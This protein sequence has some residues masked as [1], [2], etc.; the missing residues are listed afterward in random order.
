MRTRCPGHKFT[1]SLTY[2]HPR[3]PQVHCGAIR[4][5]LGFDRV[6]RVLEDDEVRVCAIRVSVDEP[7]RLVP[8]VVDV[9]SSLFVS[10][11]IPC[12]RGCKP[13]KPSWLMDH[14]KAE[15]A[16]YIAIQAQA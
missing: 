8:V 11:T 12:Y 15:G 16:R 7:E 1:D 3:I 13:L 4:N 10:D 9:E 2:L 14:L 6:V 5:S